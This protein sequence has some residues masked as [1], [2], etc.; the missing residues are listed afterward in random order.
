VEMPTDFHANPAIDG[1]VVPKRSPLR[2]SHGLTSHRAQI[3]HALPPAAADPNVPGS[4]A[5]GRAERDYE[6]SGSAY[7]GDQVSPTDSNH[8]FDS[9]QSYG[10]APSNREDNEMN[11]YGYG[12]KNGYG[13]PAPGSVGSQDADGMHPQPLAQAQAQNQKAHLGRLQ[14]LKVAAAGIHGAGEALRSTLN[15]A[16]DQQF[17]ASPETMAAHRAVAER[18]RQEVETGKLSH[19]SGLNGG[20]MSGF[21]KRVPVGSGKR[22]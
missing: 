7:G 19:N 6:N 17:H 15:G 14:G 18:G 2:E 11:A 10:T 8:T 9:H 1:P 4:V 3:A 16:V 12:G 22:T 13:V 5:Q 21:I 20:L